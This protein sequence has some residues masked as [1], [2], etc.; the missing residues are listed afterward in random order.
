M[1]C[2]VSE[3]IDPAFLKEQGWFCMG[4][5]RH[6]VFRDNV[7]SSMRA[8]RM[9]WMLASLL[10]LFHTSVLAGTPV[11]APVALGGGAA[12][13]LIGLVVVLLA[14]TGYALFRLKQQSTRERAFQDQLREQAGELIARSEQ[15]EELGQEKARLSQK[16]QDQATAFE[17]M[18]YEDDLSGLPNRRA[19]EEALERAMSRAKRGNQPLSLMLMEVA[20]VAR[21]RQELSDSIGDLVICDVGELLRRSLRGSDMP[22]RLHDAMFAVLLHDTSRDE[23]EQ[24]RARLTRLFAQFDGWGGREDGGIQVGFR[25]GVVALE[26]GDQ[27]AQA[28]CQRAERALEQATERGPATV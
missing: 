3:K 25:A 1:F 21:L 5:D 7:G 16:L 19:F 23:A 6:G 9:A 26:Q 13:L 11:T 17:K 20:D 10:L 22:A 18:A 27:T 15:L 8:T 28:L 14:I 12:L 2:L 4:Q 24:V